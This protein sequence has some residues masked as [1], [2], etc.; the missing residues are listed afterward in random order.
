[1]QVYSHPYAKA[2]IQ[3][4]LKY[5]VID[6]RQRARQNPENSLEAG[7]IFPKYKTGLYKTGSKRES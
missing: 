7:S 6:P 3:V 5:T 4:F 1:M 2:F